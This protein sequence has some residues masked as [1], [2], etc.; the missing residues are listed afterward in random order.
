MTPSSRKRDAR[1]AVFASKR[2]CW[3]M[4]GLALAATFVAPSLGYAQDE[5]VAA[6]PLVS[7]VRPAVL[8]PGP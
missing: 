2:S 5:A 4:I 8:T 1:A 7:I 6:R 3:R